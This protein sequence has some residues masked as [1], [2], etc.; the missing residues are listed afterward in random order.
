MC[1]DSSEV[2]SIAR[3]LH[4]NVP[5][6]SEKWEAL[7][8]KC[9]LGRRTEPDIVPKERLRAPGAYRRFNG[10]ERKKQFRVLLLA[11]LASA[12]RDLFGP[13]RAMAFIERFQQ[14]VGHM[15][16]SGAIALANLIPEERFSKFVARYDQM[17]IESGSAGLIHSYVNARSDPAFLTDRSFSDAF[18]HPLAIALVA[19]QIGAPVRAVD[20]RA[21]DAEPIE[22]RAQDN[23][24][25]IDNTPF[26]DEF[27]ILLTWEKHRTSGP[28]GQNFVYLPGT[29][30][31][32]RN[33]FTSSLGTIWST[34]DASIFVT[35]SAIGHAFEVQKLV[36]GRSP[37]VVEIS[38]AD[39]P[40]T[41]IFAAGSLIHHRFRTLEGRP[42]SALSIAFHSAIDNMGCFLQD[43]VPKSA[44]P[45]LQLLLGRASSDGVEFLLALAD[46]ADLIAAALA[47]TLNPVP[48]GP[49]IVER[50]A[51]ELSPE[52]VAA[53]KKALVIAPEITDLKLK[54]SSGDPPLM[55]TRIGLLRYIA[56]H[57][58]YY[59]KHGPL[60]LILY[61]DSH[62]ELRKLSRN[63][64]R[65][66]RLDDLEDRLRD[67]SDQV[68][69]PSLASILSPA[70]L[71]T[72][73]R[74]V[75]ELCLTALET[76]DHGDGP[77]R[78]PNREHLA[79]LQQLVEDL[80]EASFRC[81][82][83]QGFV[84]TTLFLFW[85]FD[86]CMLLLPHERERLK[87][88]GGAVLRS[89]IAAALVHRAAYK[90]ENYA[91]TGKVRA[92]ADGD[93]VKSE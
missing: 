21:K 5:A 24:L 81:H 70:A 66:M 3:A 73:G 56:R 93:R 32:A 19:Y 78:S 67:W 42:R 63:R 39:G 92:S 64:I 2:T 10:R 47:N 58:M 34:E 33:C 84:S 44:T 16:E 7:Q 4:L 11:T 89:Y 6:A 51:K 68:R 54:S 53:W 31:A 23:M 74:L 71:I 75:S 72:R 26:N 36:A 45:L 27:K 37:V 55:A 77:A 12:F 13:D 48:G 79:S 8:L 9:V 17:M 61:A 14:L 18:F 1:R 88:D 46:G 76:R 30:K 59:D 52:Q 83:F 65:E 57:N 87:T 82:T 91:P 60:D 69:Q 90:R 85:T 20:A 41:I 49:Q 38:F 50:S 86:E 62:E 35:E 80:C 28:R 25:H 43:D 40:T 29:H 15:E 22:V